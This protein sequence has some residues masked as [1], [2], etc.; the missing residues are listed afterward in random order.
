MKRCAARGAP[1]WPPAALASGHPKPALG[2]R[3]RGACARR[4]TGPDARAA[5]LLG[6]DR[7]EGERLAPSEGRVGSEWSSARGEERGP[8]EI[9]DSQGQGAPA[10]PPA[11]PRPSRRLSGHTG[12]WTERQSAASSRRGRSRS[13]AAL[14][15]GTNICERSIGR[16]PVAVSGLWRSRAKSTSLA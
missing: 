13:R 16:A 9:Q 3:A 15:S 5:A 1:R 8:P 4:S 14:I 7:E 12:G 11:P 6:Q 10:R 2:L